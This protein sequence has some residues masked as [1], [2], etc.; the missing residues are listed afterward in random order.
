MKIKI[1]AELPTE[2]VQTFD[3]PGAHSGEES[4]KKK[5]N[6]RMVY[7]AAVMAQL[8]YF[9]HQSAADVKQDKTRHNGRVPE[10]PVRAS[11]WAAR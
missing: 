3:Q 2:M 10:D 5:K 8:R 4:G 7:I 6:D 9:K 1:E 11:G